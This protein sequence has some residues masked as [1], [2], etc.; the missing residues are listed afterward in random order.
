MNADQF[1]GT[2]LILIGALWLTKYAATQ[3][4]HHLSPRIDRSIDAMVERALSD[5]LPDVDAPD[6]EFER[7]AMRALGFAN[8]AAFDNTVREI[9]ALPETRK[10]W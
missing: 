8:S 5:P 1:A 9:R 3:A 7:W 10:T 6:A 2:T 4:W